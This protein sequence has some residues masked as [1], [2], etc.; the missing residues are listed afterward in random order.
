KGFLIIRCT[1]DLAEGDEVCAC[2]GPHYLHNPSTED[3]RRALKE[4]YFFVCQ[5]RHCLLGEPPQLSASQSERWLGLVEKLNGEHSVRRIGGLIDKLRAL[6]RGIILFPEG[7]TF[8]S[9]LDS[10]G[11]RL[12]FEAGSTDAASVKLG[13]RLLYE[14]MAWVRDRFGPTSTEYAW[15]LGKLASLGDVGDLFEAS[16]FN[17]PSTTTQAREVFRAIMVLHYGEEEAERILSPL[18]DECGHPSASAL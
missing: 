11:Q 14:S 5:C 7:L 13:L 2:Y 4:Q 15:E 18:L 9:V 1:R 6:S 12:L 17:L 8:G 3:R 16:D 10:T